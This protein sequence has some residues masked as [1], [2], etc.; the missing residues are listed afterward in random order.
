LDEIRHAHDLLASGAITQAEFEQIKQGLLVA[1]PVARKDELDTQGD[2][3]DALPDTL[4]TDEVAESDVRQ[5]INPPPNAHPQGTLPRS[6]TSR[7]TLWIA[8]VIALVVLATA[9]GFGMQSLRHKSRKEVAPTKSTVVV[10]DLVALGGE[11]TFTKDDALNQTSD[12]PRHYGDPAFAEEYRRIAQKAGLKLELVSAWDEYTDALGGGRAG[13]PAGQDPAPGANVPAGSV[14]RLL[15]IESENEGDSSLG[16][17]SL[18][19]TTPERGSAERTAI[20]DAIRAHVKNSKL[21]FIVE[22]LYVQGD[23]ALTEVRPTASTDDG[24]FG[25][26]WCGL[27]RD[28][29][30]KWGVVDVM[31]PADAPLA[32]A[33]EWWPWASKELVAKFMGLEQTSSATDSSAQTEHSDYSG[34]SARGLDGLNVE[35]LKAGV[36]FTFVPK[37]VTAAAYSNG[38]KGAMLSMASGRLKDGT[39]VWID[40]DEVAA[41]E[42]SAGQA[43]VLRVVSVEQTGSGI[44][45]VTTR[46]EG[47]Q[48]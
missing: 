38:Q 41:E 20:M 46:V 2:T 47:V 15:L 4:V 7:R 6:A 33:M 23:G 35:D 27:Q 17:S 16:T 19:I 10:P 1:T 8:A 11:S 13:W 48:P 37:L 34:T 29:A 26:K 36:E 30:G 45:K 40:S 12:D 5:R 44:L 22:Y 24:Q 32:N 3:V 9:T 14:V 21:V 43:V 28:S 39:L 25:T 42:L 31:T 18:P